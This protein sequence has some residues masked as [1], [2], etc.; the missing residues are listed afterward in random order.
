MR[1]LG[2]LLLIPAL[3]IPL[4]ATGCVPHRQWGPGE[5]TY[6][7]Q[8]EGATHRSHVDYDHRSK[9]DQRAYWNWR[10]HHHDHD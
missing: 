5:E 8:W 6:Y 7:V 10:K 3:M 9:A 4:L 2:R 1:K